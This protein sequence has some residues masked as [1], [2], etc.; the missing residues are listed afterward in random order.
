MNDPSDK[1][2]LTLVIAIVNCG[3]GSKVYKIAKNNGVAGGTTF[4]GK[5]TSGNQILEILGLSETKKE[6]V[7][8]MCQRTVGLNVLEELGREMKLSKANHGI[9][10][11]LPIDYAVGCSTCNDCGKI[12]SEKKMQAYKSIFTIVE[13]GKAETVIEAAK[14][15][16]SK[17]GTIINARGS[18]IHETSHLFH[19]DIEPEKE[20]VLIL[21]EESAVEK[22]TEA[23]AKAVRIEEPGNG[24]IFVQSVDQVFGLR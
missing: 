18:G 14:E 22:I 12:R 16:G 1:F 6:I 23:I 24:I 4:L 21:S 8:M 13:K 11:M 5:G 19:L 7:L 15:A 17:G 20:V 3:L 2:K 10:F 9:A